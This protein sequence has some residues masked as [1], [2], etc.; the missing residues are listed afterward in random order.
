MVP[1][2][3]D[4][5][6]SLFIEILDKRQIRSVYQPLV[7][8]G[9]REIVGF[10]CLARGPEG[11][12][13]NSPMVL[14]E[15]ADRLG[16]LNEL[17]WVCRAAGLSNALNSGFP[18]SIS[19][20]IN[21]EPRTLGSTCP[22]DLLPIFQKAIDFLRIVTELTE[23]EVDRDPARLMGAAKFVRERSWGVALDDV[24]STPRSLALLPF[25]QPDVVKLDMSLIN[26]V[27]SPEVAEISNAVRAYAER[28]GAVI[29]A[30]GI[31]TTQQ[32][33]AARTLGAEY[34][35]GY[36]YGRPGAL[37]DSVAVPNHPF[38]YTQVVA[39]LG[40]KTPFEIVKA[41]RPTAISTKGLLLPMSLH[42]ERQAL[43]GGES[44]VLL[45]T[46]QQINKFTPGTQRRYR[47]LA[48]HNVFTAAIAQ[49]LRD[50]EIPGVRCVDLPLNDPLADEWNVIVVGPHFAAALV[51]R[52]LGDTGTDGDRRFD[53]FITH[54][55]DLVVQLARA[56]L[57]WVTQPV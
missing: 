6:D 56:L 11:T 25:I 50:V 32:E 1:D 47:Q 38:T 46:F 35:Q 26:G 10:E 29:L 40:Q 5:I 14:F 45:S 8:L 17:D 37:P 13:L 16:R 36:L 30:E 22:E 7:H 55:R 18:E 27:A 51:A 28:T 24:G 41:Q 52:D 54:D 31:E 21:V 23:R 57:I 20:F 49:E 9:T 15:T 33:W 42:I 53:H 48:E 3:R 43:T 4:D 2:S 39:E 44:L 12:P 34:G 19:W